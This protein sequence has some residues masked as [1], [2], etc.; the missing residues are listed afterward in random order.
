MLK[1]RQYK[2]KHIN[3]GCEVD[4][5]ISGPS[6]QDGLVLDCEAWLAGYQM[7]FDTSKSRVTQSNFAVFYKTEECRLHTNLNDRAEFGSSIYQKLNKKLEIAVNL[8]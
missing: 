7:N 3:L 6:I 4:F 2:R 8:A 1:L 5:D